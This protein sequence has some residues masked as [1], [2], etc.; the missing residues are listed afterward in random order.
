MPEFPSKD[1]SIVSDLARQVI[2]LASSDEYE[3]RRQRWR[4]VNE[5]RTPDRAPV[6]CRIALAWREVLPQDSLQCT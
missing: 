2:E 5:R 4:D 3:R 1:V 6:W